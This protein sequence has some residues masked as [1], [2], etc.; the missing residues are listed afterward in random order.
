MCLDCHKDRAIWLR[1]DS[2]SD[3]LIPI[4][5]KSTWRYSYIDVFVVLSSFDDSSLLQV[6]HWWSIFEHLEVFFDGCLPKIQIHLEH[7]ATTSVAINGSSMNFS[8]ESIVLGIQVKNLGP[9]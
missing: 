1:L 9:L 6:F 3:N 5:N 4:R 7:A 2:L 8:N